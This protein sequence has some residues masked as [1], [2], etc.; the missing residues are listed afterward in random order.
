VLW[1]S[2]SS[3]PDWS[4]LTYDVAPWRGR[5]VQVYFNAIND[6][7]GGTTAMYLDDVRLVVC[8]AGVSTAATDLPA[9]DEDTQ[10][11][12]GPVLDMTPSAPPDDSA[13]A[14]ET[15]LETPAMIF[16]TPEADAPVSQEEGQALATDA[17]VTGS[18]NPSPEAGTAPLMFFT[19]TADQMAMQGSPFES[20]TASPPPADVVGAQAPQFTRVALPVTPPVTIMLRPLPDT[21]TPPAASGTPAPPSPSEA[22]LAR[23]PRGWYFGVGLVIAI[24]LLATLIAWR[25]G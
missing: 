3:A 25:R 10:G 2:D 22:P 19:P 6:G 14:P 15:V 1:T 20:G 5:P 11:S 7:A 4:Q 12:T 13:D 8:S 21:V 24:I 17:G 18:E 16:F 9:A 23:W